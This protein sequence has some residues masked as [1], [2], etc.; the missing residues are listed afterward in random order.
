MGYDKNKAYK[1][2]RPMFVIIKERGFLFSGFSKDLKSL[3]ERMNI[4]IGEDANITMMSGW[5][6]KNLPL[7]SFN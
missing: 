5:I 1:N 7:I 4:E 2:F 6:H 3:F